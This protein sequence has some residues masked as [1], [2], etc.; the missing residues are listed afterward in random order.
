LPKARL[1]A[2]SWRE[3]TPRQVRVGS[4]LLKLDTLQKQRD[5][6]DSKKL[7]Q[8]Q[9]TPRSGGSAVPATPGTR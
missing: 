1:S 4:V 5:P 3:C 7:E 8:M 2:N 9:Q 6:D